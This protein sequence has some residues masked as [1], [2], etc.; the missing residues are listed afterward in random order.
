MLSFLLTFS[1]ERN[2]RQMIEIEVKIK[3]ADIE[4]YH[5]KLK[6]LGAEC[7]KPRH[8]EENVL[9]D[10]SE[11]PLFHRRK[12]LR[13]RRMGKKTFLTFKGTPQRS[14]Q[15]KIRDEFE[16]EI[17]NQKEMKKILKALGLKPVYEYRKHRT[18]YKKK[19]IKICL[20]EISI[21]QFIELEGPQSDIVRFAQTLGFSRKDFIKDD[22]IS[23]LSQ[24]KK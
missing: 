3:I 18:V 5:D 1:A 12:A 16:T 15:F 9:Y 17:K 20:D 19:Q 21:G 8:F 7:I 4:P 13:L 14:R 10:Y 23:L 2:S 6:R 22:Y 24:E 11:K